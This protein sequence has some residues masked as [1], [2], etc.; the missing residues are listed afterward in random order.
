M[1]LPP[2]LSRLMW[3]AGLWVAGVLIVAIIAYAIRLVLLY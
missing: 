1:Q 2:T 3:F